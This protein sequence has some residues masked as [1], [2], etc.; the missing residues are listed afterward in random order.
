MKWN[1]VGKRGRRRNEHEK[2]GFLLREKEMT[3]F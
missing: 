2:E 1:V 3:P